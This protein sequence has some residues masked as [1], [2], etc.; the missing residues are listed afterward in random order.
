MAILSLQYYQ[1]M[2]QKCAEQWKEITESESA[3]NHLRTVKDLKS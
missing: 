2:I 1:A 3:E